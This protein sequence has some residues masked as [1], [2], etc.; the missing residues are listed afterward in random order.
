MVEK[1][2]L[3][4]T[5]GPDPI[6]ADFAQQLA[7]ISTWFII[8]MDVAFLLP[9]SLIFLSSGFSWES[10][11][12]TMVGMFYVMSILFIFITRISVIPIT[13]NMLIYTNGIE[14]TSGT[15]KRWPGIN[16]FVEKDNIREIEII[17]GKGR[18]AK[19]IVNLKLKKGW[20]RRLS[21]R[22]PDLKDALSKIWAPMLNVPVVEK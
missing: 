2:K 21:A 18:H 7:R 10:S 16:R 19:I 17:K 13:V 20:M 5:M 15:G 1:G 22:D 11:D 12:V 3:I 14:F 8:V 9:I 6:Y 4:G